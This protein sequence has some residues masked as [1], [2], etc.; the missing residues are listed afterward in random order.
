MRTGTQAHAKAQFGMPDWDDIVDAASA[1]VRKFAGGISSRQIMSIGQQVYK[2]GGVRMSD[3]KKAERLARKAA[4]NEVAN[5]L[6]MKIIEM[7]PELLNVILEENV[8]VLVIFALEMPAVFSDL[9][10]GE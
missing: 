8:R 3:L 6:V 1:V 2:N 10:N 4:E 5:Q 9:L 7:N